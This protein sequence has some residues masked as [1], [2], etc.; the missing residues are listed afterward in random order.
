ME[1]PISPLLIRV[2]HPGNSKNKQTHRFW[3]FKNWPKIYKKMPNLSDWSTCLPSSKSLSYVSCIISRNIKLIR[4]LTNFL[5]K[6][7]KLWAL[8]RKVALFWTKLNGIEWALWKTLHIIIITF[9]IFDTYIPCQTVQ[10]SKEII[11]KSNLPKKLP[12]KENKT[13]EKLNLDQT[14]YFH[15]SELVIRI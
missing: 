8:F 13:N 5:S 7:R 2:S 4:F 15:S 14:S 9:C 11:L 10:N 3:S 1:V 6:N 12:K